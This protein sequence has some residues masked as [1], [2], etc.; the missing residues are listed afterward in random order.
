MSGSIQD[1]MVKFIAAR[2]AGGVGSEELAGEFL[3]PASAPPALCEKLLAN[4]LQD[5]VRV[6]RNEEGVWTAIASG[7]GGG[8]AGEFAVIETCDVAA[9]AARIAVEWAGV[10]MDAKGDTVATQEAVIRAEPW[11]QGAVLPAH[12]R[13][14][15]PEGMSLSAAVAAAVEFT[16]GA[17]VVSVRPGRFQ[18]ELLRQLTAG[19]A[20][21]GQLFLGRL[22]RQALGAGIRTV[23]DIAGRLGV[24]VRRP[25]RAPERAGYVAELLAAMLSQQNQLGLGEPESWVARQEPKRFDVDFSGFDF[26]REFL[27]R[28]PAR[29]GVYTMRDAAGEVIYVGKAVDLRRRVG[30]YFRARVRRDEKTGQILERLFALEVEETGSELAALLLEYRLICEFEPEIN[31]QYEVHDRCAG[32]RAPSRRWVVVLPGV[33]P[34]EAEVFLFYGDRTLRRT[35]VPRAE[36]ERLRPALAGFFFGPSA[37]E[38]EAD[39]ERGWLQIAWSWLERHRD[40]ANAFDVELAGGLD[41][42]MRLLAGYLREEESGNRVYH[43]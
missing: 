35:I 19:G 18:A 36:T 32:R 3:A 40:A 42:T 7:S 37:P 2:G 4:V 31:R 6:A 28:L 16:R 24:P 22:A 10:R 33:H 23:E 12:L 30:D 41:E 29:P 5:D 39:S 17:T 21:G 15:Q 9:G 20:P 8:G 11:P 43:V 13:G 27:D 14:R 26:D 25:E 38:P 1:K 34:E